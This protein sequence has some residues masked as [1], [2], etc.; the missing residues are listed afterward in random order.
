MEAHK[1]PFFSSLLEQAY[2]DAGTVSDVFDSNDWNDNWNDGWDDDDRSLK[3]S[4]RLVRSHM[5]LAA[6]KLAKMRLHHSQF[7]QVLGRGK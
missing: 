5:D 2:A 3:N 6:Q 4:L 1:P 7:A